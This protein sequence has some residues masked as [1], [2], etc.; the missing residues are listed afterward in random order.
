MKKLGSGTFTVAFKHPSSKKVILKSVDPV[1]RAMASG[2]LPKSDLFPEVVFINKET[3]RVHVY[4]MK[5]YKTLSSKGIGTFDGIEKLKTVLTPK[6]ARL[7]KE[8]VLVSETNSE[9]IREFIEEIRNISNEFHTEREEIIRYAK[10][11]SKETKRKLIFEAQPFNVAVE[12]KKLILFDCF[13]PMNVAAYY[14]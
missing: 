10:A 3:H 1:K 6:H 5:H 9:G 4:S 13:Y 12:N 8:L 7:Y 2:R 11:L 14:N